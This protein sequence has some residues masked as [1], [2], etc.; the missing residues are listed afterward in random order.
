[1]KA[2]NVIIRRCGPRT[3]IDFIRLVLGMSDVSESLRRVNNIIRTHR[4]NNEQH[5]TQSFAR[6]NELLERFR[7]NSNGK[8]EEDSTCIVDHVTTIQKALYS[9]LQFKRNHFFNSTAM[10][11][12]DVEKSWTEHIERNNLEL[13][14][15]LESVSRQ[16]QDQ[17]QCVRNTRKKL[18]DDE[19]I[20]LLFDEREIRSNLMRETNKEKLENVRR[21]ALESSGLKNQLASE[22]DKTQSL[23]NVIID[24][25]EEVIN[26]KR[27]VNEL[28]AEVNMNNGETSGEISNQKLFIALLQRQ[29]KSV[30]EKN[31]FLENTLEI[32]NKDV[33]IMSVAI[34]RKEAQIKSFQSK[35]TTSENMAQIFQ[36]D[37]LKK[38]KIVK[39]LENRLK[40]HETE[41]KELSEL[42]S[43]HHQV[44][45]ECF[46]WKTKC[47][48]VEIGSS[49]GMKLANMHSEAAEEMTNHLK[50]K[51]ANENIY[52]KEVVKELHAQVTHV[53]GNDT[54]GIHH[55]SAILYSQHFIDKFCSTAVEKIKHSI[56]S[57]PKEKLIEKTLQQTL[58]HVFET[59]IALESIKQSGAFLNSLYL[60][61]QLKFHLELQNILH[62][63]EPGKSVR[64]TQSSIIQALE[65]YQHIISE[66]D[67]VISKLGLQV[68]LKTQQHRKIMTELE[69]KDEMLSECG[70]LLQNATSKTILP[71]PQ[72]QSQN[73]KLSKQTIQLEPLE[74]MI[75]KSP[76]CPQSKVF[77]PRI[78]EKFKESFDMEASFPREESQRVQ[79]I[80]FGKNTAKKILGRA[81]K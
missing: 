75:Q 26:L 64:N 6:M 30:L 35:A 25:R 40:L 10:I 5:D 78:R 33:Q 47:N 24:L 69:K 22:K 49:V 65:K 39:E 60:E 70:K 41:A 36:H 12:S 45:E 2:G 43:N 52:F 53:L 57:V 61:F 34:E 42:R 63:L 37:L 71:A 19:K 50:V 13:N 55:H 7:Q 27:K 51:I 67:M 8:C 72:T 38:D 16:H 31:G 58:Q 17:L 54:A 56:E 21:F 59:K 32:R 76:P 20:K 80:I 73:N 28:Q 62:Q 74:D 77:E 46:F 66:K 81:R 23:I 4:V 11:Y 68:A 79:T 48:A 3:F 29:L 18:L 1:L 15:K 14:D 44:E 9:V